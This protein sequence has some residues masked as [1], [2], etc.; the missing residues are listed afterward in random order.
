[1]RIVWMHRSLYCDRSRH[2]GALAVRVDPMSYLEVAGHRIWHEV[3]GSGDPV[4]LLHGAFTG[5]TSFAAQAPYLER[6]GRQVYVPERPGHAHSPDLDEPFGY[7]RM[8]EHT[9]DYL[10]EV[11]DGPADLI[12]W[13]DGAVVALLVARDSPEL[14]RRQVLIGQ[15]FNSSGRATD[16]EVE[17]MLGA[18]ETIGFLRAEYDAVS[19]DGPEHF[20]VVHAKT[21]RMIATEPEIDLATLDR[22]AAPTLVVQG[23]RDLVTIAHSQAVVGALPH[24]R[25]A[26]LPG[27]HL[28]PIEAPELINPMLDRFLD[29]G[30]GFAESP[31][32]G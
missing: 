3:T 16:D 17:E 26:V 6:A 32:L 4:V 27:T 24:G 25:L 14:V 29:P 10:R 20:M 5:A 7:Q 19:P 28:L 1:M 11:L 18:A 21:M 2:R 9:A 15:Y 12:G 22:V 13:S 30:R 23:D 8:A 31:S